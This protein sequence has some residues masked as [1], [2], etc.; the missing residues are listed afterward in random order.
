MMK[1]GRFLWM[2]MLV[3]LMA[4]LA[5]TLWTVILSGRPAEARPA[6][7]VAMN[8]NRDPNIFSAC[9]ATNGITTNVQLVAAP[10]ADTYLYVTD[11]VIS[12]NAAMTVTIHD[13][14]AVTVTRIYAPANGGFAEHFMTPQK[15]TLAKALQIDLGAVGECSATVA[16]FKDQR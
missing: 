2:L 14:N 6:E 12:A 11:I 1:S 4:A 5:G 7:G 10:A 13:S 9:V 15:C 3:V 16:G 8:S